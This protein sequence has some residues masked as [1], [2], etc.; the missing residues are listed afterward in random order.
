MDTERIAQRL[1]EL[2]RKGQY[3]EAQKELYA[4]TAVSIEPEGAPPGAMG[5]A[6]GLQAILEK[7][8]RFSAMIETFHGTTVSDPLVAGNWFSIKMTLDVTMQ[9]RG[10]MNMSEICVYAVRDGKITR[11][12]FFFD[13]G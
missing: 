4:E 10:R 8:R 2:C 12:Q 3:E 1:V 9:G 6:N 5:N 13:F 11:E 7:G